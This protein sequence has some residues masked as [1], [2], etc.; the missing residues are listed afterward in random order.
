MIN[1]E[2]SLQSGLA[3][4][5]SEENAVSF[6]GSRSAENV[7]HGR[8]LPSLILAQ[9]LESIVITYSAMIK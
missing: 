9:A 3:L 2:V 8:V 5:H 4:I 1:R 6:N 7:P